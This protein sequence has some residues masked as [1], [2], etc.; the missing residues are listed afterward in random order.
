[1]NTGCLVEPY[2]NHST[3]TIG[4]VS[5][6]GGALERLEGAMG[7]IMEAATM[8]TSKRNA[9]DIALAVDGRGGDLWTAYELD[10]S[11]FYLR[12]PPEYLDNGLDLVIDLAT[13]ATL[14]EGAILAEKERALFRLRSV[15]ADPLS[16]LLSIY[17][18]KAAFGNGPFSKCILGTEGSIA[19][20]DPSAARLQ[21]SHEFPTPPLLP[22]AV[23]SI[24]EPEGTEQR[25]GSYMAQ[26]KPIVPPK[27]IDGSPGVPLGLETHRQPSENAYI[28]IN[29][30]TPG[31]AQEQILALELS[32]TILGEAPS[33]RIFREVREKRGLSYIAFSRLE[34]FRP[35]GIFSAI[36]D[37]KP[38]RLEEALDI[39][40]EE[41]KGL[42]EAEVPPE[43]FEVAK[44]NLL[45]SYDIRLDNS[46]SIASHLVPRK[47]AGSPMS[48]Q[49]EYERIQRIKPTD[50]RGAWRDVFKERNIS[51]AVV[52]AF[53][54]ILAKRA[55]DKIAWR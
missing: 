19:D 6:Y 27:S 24:S 36:C 43:E 17:R 4:L 55:W 37:V 11:G 49:D 33:S 40:V 5:S 28:S 8:G 41:L 1:M 46:A 44:N 26:I 39:M 21:Y 23:G 52:G 16:S 50:V 15:I 12:L 14:S 18:L 22:F 20:L 35:A 32:S 51:L 13:N 9:Q 42:A 47:L 45:G 10:L 54:E 29:V 34:L 48:Y 30:V 7:I 53:D 38:E 2:T 3:I 31:I 25:I